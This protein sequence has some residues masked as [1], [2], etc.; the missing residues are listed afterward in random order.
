MIT[1]LKRLSRPS[2]TRPGS[3]T[4]LSAFGSML[5]PQSK[6]TTRLP[7]RRPS[8]PDKQAA[9][10]VAAAPS[11]TPFSSSTMRKIERAICSSLTITASSTRGWEISNALLPT[12]GMASPSASVGRKAMRVG[13]PASS[14]AEKLATFSASTAMIFA[15]AFFVFTASATP[16]SSPAPPTGTITAS[17]SGTCSRISNP[18]VPWPAI[19]AGSS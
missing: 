17:T 15:L 4:R 5:P 3:I 12:W 10:G 1:A 6:R 16:A 8:F 19:I 13:F 2:A 11:T 14:A 7:A 18:I 9:R